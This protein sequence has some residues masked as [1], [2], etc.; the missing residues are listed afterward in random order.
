FLIHLQKDEANGGR[1]L[2]SS[3]PAEVVERAVNS[4]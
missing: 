4:L 2:W 1:D 3:M